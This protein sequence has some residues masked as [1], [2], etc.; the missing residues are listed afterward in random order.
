LVYEGDRNRPLTDCRRHTL[1]AA[2]ANVANRED[3]GQAGF[4]E[5]WSPGERPTSSG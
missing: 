2:S 5:M 4:K 1:E 3:S